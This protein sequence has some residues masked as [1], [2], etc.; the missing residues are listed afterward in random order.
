MDAET[1]WIPGEPC[2]G[3]AAL[4]AVAAMRFVDLCTRMCVAFILP[5]SASEYLCTGFNTIHLLP[6]AC[7]CLR[8]HNPL[9]WQLTEA[10]RSGPNFNY[11]CEAAVSLE[12]PCGRQLAF[13]V[14]GEIGRWWVA[15]LGYPDSSCPFSFHRAARRKPPTLPS[16][17]LSFVCVFLVLLKPPPTPTHALPLPV[18]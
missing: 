8:H 16:L 7:R 12:E 10:V 14:A 18:S 9:P 3:P 13:A 5:L 1:P 11:A 4:A 15:F 6:Q 2:A 17:E